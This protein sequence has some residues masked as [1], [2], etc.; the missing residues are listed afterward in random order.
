MATR[1][2]A[3][4]A[5]DEEQPPPGKRRRVEEGAAVAPLPFI[6]SVK[7]DCLVLILSHLSTNDLNN[8]AMCSRRFREVRAHE[9]LNQTRTGTIICREGTTIQALFDAI[10][11]RR[12]NQVFQGNR[13][14]L[15]IV[16]LERLTE[17]S[18]FL[19]RTRSAAESVLT[20]VTSLDAS[21][22]PQDANRKVNQMNTI[23][24]LCN[25]LPNLSEVNLSFMLIAHVQPLLYVLSRCRNLTR[26]TWK[27]CDTP[28]IMSR[29]CF[30][31]ANH[32]TELYLDDSR[33]LIYQN[34]S[35]FETDPINDGPNLYMFMDC[36][37]PERLSIK[38]A[39]WKSIST[40]NERGSLN[41]YQPLSQEM[42]I[43]MVRNHST[44]RWLR[45]DLTPENVAMLQQERPEITFCQ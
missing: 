44:L 27:G 2:A 3:F 32:L 36:C 45:S 31:Y 10:V 41:E 13:T 8:V 1:K 24:S 15:K 7:D 23:S 18:H 11:L 33:F 20:G 39:T 14:H 42:L 5:K 17:P 34:A 25:M 28:P 30:R 9:S 19:V 12:W 21:C 29:C 4:D 22:S 40:S 6:E 26:L 37:R 16:G 38:N 43:K 35:R